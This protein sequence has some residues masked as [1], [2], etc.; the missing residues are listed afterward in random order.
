MYFKTR[1]LIYIDVQILE[2]LGINKDEA[3]K[4][5]LHTVWPYL[6]KNEPCNCEAKYHPR[7]QPKPSQRAAGHRV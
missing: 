3:S 6:S 2:S 7:F 1:K 5:Q 4:V